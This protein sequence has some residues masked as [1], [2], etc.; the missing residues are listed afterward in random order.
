[1]TKSGYE[2]LVAPGSDSVPGSAD[3]CNGVPADSLST[4]VYATANPVVPGS[5]GN[6]YFWRGASGSIFQDTAPITEDEGFSSTP[7]GQPIQ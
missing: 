7:G 2:V 4:A 5:T 3:A 1:V 6:W